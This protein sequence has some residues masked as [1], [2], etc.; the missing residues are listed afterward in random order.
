V[1]PSVSAIVHLLYQNAGRKA[2]SAHEAGSS[3]CM[4]SEIRPDTTGSG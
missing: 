1:I 2:H 3:H 4:F